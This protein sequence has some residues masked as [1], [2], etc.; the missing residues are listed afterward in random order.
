MRLLK[1]LPPPKPSRFSYLP[2]K[3][4]VNN[5]RSISSIYV[6]VVRVG[7]LTNIQ[8]GVPPEIFHLGG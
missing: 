5:S 1:M 8:Q 6:S 4:I 2:I 3:C 7:G